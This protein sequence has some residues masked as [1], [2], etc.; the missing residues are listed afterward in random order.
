MPS[1]MIKYNIS[2]ETVVSLSDPREGLEISELGL[3]ILKTPGLIPQALKPM[4]DKRLALKKLLRSTT[5]SDPRYSDLRERYKA[6]ARI[7]NQKAVAD[8]IKWFAMDA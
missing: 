5:K 7:T 6:L 3:K 4:R 1:L 8:A 2:P